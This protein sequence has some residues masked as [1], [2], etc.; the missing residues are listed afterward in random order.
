MKVGD[1]V[2]CIKPHSNGVLVVGKIYV[3]GGIYF[4][5]CCGDMLLDVGIGGSG[6]QFCGD[7]KQIYDLGAPWWI[8]SKL[9]APLEEKSDTMFEDIFQVVTNETRL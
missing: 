6:L 7:C 1:R 3:V 5:P 4:T 2:V 9:F 8:S